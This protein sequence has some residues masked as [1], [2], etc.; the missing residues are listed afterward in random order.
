MNN[1]T[2]IGNL[3]AD[4]DI[5]YFETGKVKASFSLAVNEGKEKVTFIDCEAWAGTAEL[6]G[7]HCKKGEKLG[8]EARYA[9]DT[10]E[11][12]GQ[13]RTKS[14]FVCNSITFCSTKKAD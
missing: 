6:I 12:E 2:F 4:P 11:K 1:C 7:Q 9:K 14:Y 8:V 10:Y 13:K 5:K 3:T